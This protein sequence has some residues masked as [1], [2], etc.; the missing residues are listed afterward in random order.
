MKIVQTSEIPKHIVTEFFI[1]HWGSP[2]M[3][4]SSGTYQCDELDG[5]AVLDE[6]ERIIGLITYIIFKNECEIISLDSTVENKGIGTTLIQKVEEAVKQKQCNQIKLVTTNDN[7]HALGFYQRK[8]YRLTELYVDAVEIARKRKPEI[9][10]VAENGIPIRDE[11]LLV[12][13]LI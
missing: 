1:K 3:V 5:Y 11:I 10:L 8:G 4:I 7:L 2:K 12:K 9:P 6:K 13:K